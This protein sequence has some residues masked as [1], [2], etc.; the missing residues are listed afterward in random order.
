MRNR[1]VHFFGNVSMT[2]GHEGL[3]AIAAEKVDVDNLK[4]G[5]FVA[6]IN[7]SFSAM[8]LLCAHGVLIHWRQPSHKALYTEVVDTLPRFLSG[9]DVGFSREVTA[10]ISRYYRRHLVAKDRGERVTSTERSAA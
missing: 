1:V 6:F 10:A 7:K 2:N 5:E 4:P 9:M 8:K 3:A